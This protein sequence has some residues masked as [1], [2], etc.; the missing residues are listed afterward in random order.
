MGIVGTAAQTAVPEPSSFVLGLIALLTTAG[1]VRA[2][3]R[4]R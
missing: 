1:C 3:R 4:I 2:R